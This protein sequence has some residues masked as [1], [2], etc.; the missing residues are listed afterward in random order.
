MGC[1][2]GGN[3][4]VSHRRAAF[5]RKHRVAT[6]MLHVATRRWFTMGMMKNLRWYEP[7][8][9]AWQP[10]PTIRLRGI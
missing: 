5:K 3:D 7:L 9:H 2:N 4:I 1:G 8:V 6:C 10:A